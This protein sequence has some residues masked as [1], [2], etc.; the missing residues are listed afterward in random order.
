MSFDFEPVVSEKFRE[1]SAEFLGDLRASAADKFPQQVRDAFDSLDFSTQPALVVE[2][3]KTWAQLHIRT[4]IS[5]VDMMVTLREA[6][7][8]SCEHDMP[9]DTPDELCVKHLMSMPGWLDDPR[10]TEL[11]EK[12]IDQLGRIFVLDMQMGSCNQ[13]L[14][15]DPRV[16]KFLAYMRE[17]RAIVHDVQPLRDWHAELKRALNRAQAELN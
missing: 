6:A 12:L 16:D 1:F 8:F 9:A 15:A 14:V 13:P 7:R 10:I 3:A 4:Y 17:V 2:A 11:P 5:F